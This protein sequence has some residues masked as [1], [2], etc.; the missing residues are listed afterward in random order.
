MTSVFKKF[1]FSIWPPYEAYETNKWLNDKGKQ[2][3]KNVLWEQNLNEF[4]HV[5]SCELPLQEI[6]KEA[7][8]IQEREISRKNTIEQKASWLG[9][10]TGLSVA[11][12]SLVP[13]FLDPKWN[14]PNSAKVLALLF[15]LFSLINFIVGAYY[16]ILVR[17]VSAYCGPSVEGIVGKCR[18]GKWDEKKN[19]AIILT[20][21]KWN[22]KIITMKINY[23][24]VS[25]NLFL[26]G[27]AFVAVSTI[28]LLYYVII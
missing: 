5:L 9:G 16:S 11:I 20:E 13:V 4:L 2:I 3:D 18:N 7:M 1:L 15:Y 21:I 14:I 8:A 6:K 10:S 17:K 23:L 12:I 19:I 26:R 22:E 27:T 24:S 25:E 28:I